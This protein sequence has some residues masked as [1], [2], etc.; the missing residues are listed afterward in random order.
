MAKSKVDRVVPFV[1]N[2]IQCQWFV[3]Q[4]RYPS[5]SVPEWVKVWQRPLIESLAPLVVE[6]GASFL[7]DT[8]QEIKATFSS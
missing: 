6:A 1:A 4:C 3:A 5:W 8:L 2:E 7:K